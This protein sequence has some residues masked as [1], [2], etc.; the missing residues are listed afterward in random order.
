MHLKR[1]TL[2]LSRKRSS[3]KVKLIQNRDRSIGVLII[4]IST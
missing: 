3:I 4:V 1:E 2:D